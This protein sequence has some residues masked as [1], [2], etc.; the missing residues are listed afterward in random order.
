LLSRLRP[1]DMHAAM[2]ELAKVKESVSHAIADS[3]AE[4]RE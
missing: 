2:N 1:D 3:P 4:D